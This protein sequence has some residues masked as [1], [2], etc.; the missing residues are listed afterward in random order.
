[1]RN[2]YCRSGEIDIIAREGGYLVFAE[3]KYRSADTCGLPQ[4][5]VDSRKIRHLVRAARYYLYAHGMSDIPCR[6]DVVTILGSQ[7]S[8]IQN[9]FEAD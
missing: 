6:F 8:V 5:A 1:M 7:V 3:V 9:A 4:E 2:Y